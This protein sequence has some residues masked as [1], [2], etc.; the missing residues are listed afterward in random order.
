MARYDLYPGVD[1]AGYLLDIQADLLEELSTRVVVPLV[2]HS[3]KVKLVR[4]L[5]PVF[6]IDGKQHAMFTHLIAAVPLTRLREPRTNLL[7]RQRGGGY[8]SRLAALRAL[9]SGRRG[10][11]RHSTPS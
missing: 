4:K 5:N 7:S 8:P 3:G 6:N 1:R 10:S 9:R 11:Q 2:P